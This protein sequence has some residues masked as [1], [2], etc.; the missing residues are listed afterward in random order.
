MNRLMSIGSIVDLFAKDNYTVLSLEFKSSKQKIQYRCSNGH[1]HSMRL[2]HWKRGIRCPYCSIN[3]KQ[4]ISSVKLRFESE[5]YTLLSD[6]YTGSDSKLLTM[7]SKG[8]KYMTSWHNWNSGRRCSKCNGGLVK[9]K[10]DVEDILQNEGYTLVS[11][12]INSNIPIIC[13][14]PN[15]HM[16]SVYLPNF[17]FKNSRCTICSGAGSSA[18]ESILRTFLFGLGIEFECNNRTLIKPYELDIVIPSKKI[19]IEYCGL[20]WHSELS[21]KDKNY[22]LNKLEMCNKIGYDLIT[23]F[24]D[25]LLYKKDIVFSKLRSIINSNTYDLYSRMFTTKEISDGEAKEFLDTNHIQGYDSSSEIRVGAF[26][27]ERLIAVMIFSKV[28]DDGVY[29]LCRF[30]GVKDTT[31]IGVDYVLFKYFTTNYDYKEVYLYADRRWPLDDLHVNIGFIFVSNTAPNYWYIKN[32]KRDN[33][34]SIIEFEDKNMVGYDKIWDCG[35]T[36]Y[37]Y[38]GNTL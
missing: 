31:I 12:Y 29:E 33:K 11:E 28:C 27:D 32:K 1:E 20:Y 10:V 5:G 15:G 25:E 26:Y 23:I 14:C 13:R 24:E 34:D 9:D 18:G 22:H 16:Y 21:G 37:K 35:T 17:I 30:C 4:S 36:K 2:D 38:K 7:C 8:H 3:S 6:T 19:A